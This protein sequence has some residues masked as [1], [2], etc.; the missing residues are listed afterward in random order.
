MSD[1][2]KSFVTE[3]QPIT[4]QVGGHILSALSQ[5]D[6]AAVLTSIVPGLGVDRVASIPVSQEQLILIHKILH[7][8]QQ[9][10]ISQPRS[11]EEEERN[12]GFQVEVPA[13]KENK[14]VE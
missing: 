3:I 2:V 5:K 11:E 8:H 6:T 14:A 1:K 10:A 4:Q 12:I 9:K 7:A 13:Q